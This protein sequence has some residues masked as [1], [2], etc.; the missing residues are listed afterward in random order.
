VADHSIPSFEAKRATTQDTMISPG[1]LKERL[2]PAVKDYAET[3]HEAAEGQDV[4][5]VES[6]ICPTE[7]GGTELVEL[8]VPSR[9]IE[10][11]ID[12]DEISHFDDC[13]EWLEDAE[14]EVHLSHTNRESAYEHRLR[15][16]ANSVLNYVGSYDFNKEAYQAAFSDNLKPHFNE[17]LSLD[18]L[19]PIPGLAEHS[20]PVTFTPQSPEQEDEQYLLT[21]SSDFS[22]NKI[23]ASE[24]AALQNKSMEGLYGDPDKLGW[25]GRLRYTVDINDRRQDFQV[26]D[27][28]AEKATDISVGIARKVVDGLR[29]SEPQED[30]IWFGP[31]FALRDNWL[32][33]RTGAEAV[34]QAHLHPDCDIEYRNIHSFSLD[35]W[36]AKSFANAFWEE[37]ADLLT[38]E[39]FDRPL[40]RFNR[41]YLP[42]HA[43]DH[44]L[45]CHIALESLLL[46]GAKGGTSFRMPV[47]AAILLR[48]RVRDPVEVYYFFDFFLFSYQFS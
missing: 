24:M 5:P 11:L 22:V 23:T 29:I 10:Y 48:D 9:G 16:F 35:E 17:A 37:K 32:T 38:S 45:D 7:D 44:I 27:F 26:P 30:N 42:G 1:E 33:Y 46:K 47:G 36:G 20:E 12:P 21:V 3:V 2:R 18:I 25:E 15:S 41:T 19:V 28:L 43:E 39:M 14:D 31:I 34:E 6:W 40:R 13:A 8:A 4:H